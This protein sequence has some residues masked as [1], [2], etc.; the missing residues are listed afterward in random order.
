MAKCPIDKHTNTHWR[1][2]IAG[3]EYKI[4]VRV[5]SF[6]H[7]TMSI[8]TH[9]FSKNKRCMYMSFNQSN[10]ATTAGELHK[11]PAV[12]QPLFLMSSMQ[13]MKPHSILAYHTQQLDRFTI[14]RVTHPEPQQQTIVIVSWHSQATGG[15]NN[16]NAYSASPSQVVAL[17]AVSTTI[18]QPTSKLIPAAG[19]GN[20]EQMTTVNIC[21]ILLN[22]LQQ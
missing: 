5:R 13:W 2:I 17:D 3:S 1:V 18:Q 20:V 4:S 12:F 7:N 6:C 16:T 14:R 22:L 15:G 11:T 19:A 8:V 10:Q 9:V 21:N